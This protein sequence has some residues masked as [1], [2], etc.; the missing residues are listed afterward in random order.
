MSHRGQRKNPSLNDVVES[1]FDTGSMPLLVSPDGIS[2]DKLSMTHR[3]SGESSN[4]DSKDKNSRCAANLTFIFCYNAHP[5]LTERSKIDSVQ[6]AVRPDNIRWAICGEKRFA[7][8]ITRL[9]RI[10]FLCQFD[11]RKLENLR[12][13]PAGEPSHQYKKIIIYKDLISINIK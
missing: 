10:D 8:V 11:S 2:E 3:S 7:A 9:P 4:V 6:N 1:K 12:E 5:W 13:N